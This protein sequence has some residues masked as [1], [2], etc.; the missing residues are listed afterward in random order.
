MH[1]VSRALPLAVLLVLAVTPSLGAFTRAPDRTVDHRTT[2]SRPSRLGP[3]CPVGPPGAVVRAYYA[4]AAHHR[5]AAVRACFAPSVVAVVA[6][7]NGMYA[8]WNNTISARVTRMRVRAVP[9]SYLGRRGETTFTA[10][11]LDQI[12]VSVVMHYRHVARTPLH[13]GPNALF[14]YVAQQHAASPW[15]IVAMGTGP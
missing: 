8:P 3:L 15:R 9:V 13:N 14:I 7:A 6:G 12:L 5:R 4:A 10:V 1:P 11:H 2:S